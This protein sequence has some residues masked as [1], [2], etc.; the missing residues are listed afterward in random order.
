MGMVGGGDG[1]LIG[2]V[3][4]QA[5]GMTGAIE[6]VAGAFSSDA[7]A[8]RRFGVELGLAKERAYGDYRQM[9]DAEAALPE[10]QRIQCVSIVTPNGSH[11]DIACMALERG[12]H[13][14]CDKPLAGH[15]EDALRI[16][17]AVRESGL[18]FGLTHTY[19]GYP[20]VVEARER[21]RSGE[22]GAIRR[23]TV[24][25]LQD[26]LSR[27][28]DTSASKQA[29][30]RTDPDVGGE[31]GA[32]AD[33]GTHAFNLVE[34]VTG[35]Q[36][37]A[38]AAELRA[39]VAG[40]RIDDDGA[41]MFRL[42]GGASG[43]MSVSQ[44]CAGAANGL[45]IEVYGDRASLH[46]AHADPSLL[47]IRQRGEPD[48]VLRPGNNMDYL[49]A[50]ARRRTHLPGGHPEGFHEAFANLYADFAAAVSAWPEPAN[51]ISATVTDGVRGMRFIRA[52]IDSSRNN[53]Q[54]T[55]IETG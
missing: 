24:S 12:M 52:A 38:I 3:H 53:S 26:W 46:W 34:F 21:V 33:I 25:Y 43:V 23:V 32:F 19:T 4:R 1:A 8:S 13:V 15:L 47:T 14:I 49:S 10:D 45:V 35:E 37:S 20:L 5:A 18:V 31:S 40:R 28:E 6:L 7:A 9:L 55:T 50:A 39:V 11:A 17:A 42:S 29:A 30:W 36:V 22:L 51:G 2:A 44:V 27:P 54:W 48:R 16:E 41:A